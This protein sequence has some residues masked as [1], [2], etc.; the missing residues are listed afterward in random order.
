[1]SVPLTHAPNTKSN[2]W[3]S[4]MVV[5]VREVERP[6]RC[7]ERGRGALGALAWSSVN[8]EVALQFQFMPCTLLFFQAIVYYATDSPRL[9]LELVRQH[10]KHIDD[11]LFE[12]QTIRLG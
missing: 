4:S 8:R 9:S 11:T 2:E 10:I 1:M 3:M 7:G 12:L 5:H 6:H